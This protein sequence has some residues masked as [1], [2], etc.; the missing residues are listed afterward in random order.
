VGFKVQ[1]FRG[2][3]G[4]AAHRPH[5]AF[6][7][8]TTAPTGERGVSREAWQ[9]KAILAGGWDLGNG[10][11]FSV[12]LGTEELR[13]GSERYLRSWLSGSL[14][15]DLRER[16][17]AFLELVVSEPEAPSGPSTLVVQAGLT[18][19]LREDLQLDL[20][21]ARRGTREGPDWL[22]GGGSQLPVQAGEV[23]SSSKVERAPLALGGKEGLQARKGSPSFAEVAFFSKD[24]GSPLR[25]RGSRA[26]NLR[27][28]GGGSRGALDLHPTRRKA[29]A[30]AAVG[31]KDPRRRTLPSH[32]S[33]VKRTRPWV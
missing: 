7:L 5:W 4:G 19:W 6:I 23:E 2:E 17:A 8:A 32:A 13:Q 29:E 25:T 31:E 20:R 26:K 3:M 22:V 28:P 18:H 10:R 30:R 12:N 14:G 1:L 21:A 24:L 27:S 33:R 11:S 15:F 16:T 9:P